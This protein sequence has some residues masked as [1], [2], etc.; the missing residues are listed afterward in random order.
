VIQPV[1]KITIFLLASAALVHLAGQET[2]PDSTLQGLNPR[3]ALLLGLVPGGGQVYN[4]NFLK[5][6]LFMAAE[7]YY[8]YKFQ[9]YRNLYRNF[10]ASQSGY[11][12]TR[13]LEKRNKY[14]WW[15]FFV[16]LW[17]MIDGYVDAHLS[18]FPQDRLMQESPEPAQSVEEAP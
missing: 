1:A 12:K 6:A 4:R 16:Y 15:V 13:Y 5:A 18:S 7:G 10:D 3:K 11:L 2:T 8:V 9:E 17:S 14:A